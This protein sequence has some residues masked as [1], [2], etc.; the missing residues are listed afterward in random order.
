KIGQ[1]KTRHKFKCH[2]FASNFSCIMSENCFH[3]GQ[4]IIKERIPFDDKVFCCAGCKSVFEILNANDLG[5]FYE[6]NKRSGIR[7]DGA[8]N[9]QFDYLDTPEIFDK[10]TDFSEGTTTLVNF[11]IP[12]IHCSSCIW[13]LESLHTLNSNIHYSQVNFTRKTVQISFNSEEL[14]LSE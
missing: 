6:L 7:P 1:L 12:V 10:V 5:T 11:K 3:C 14:K 8:Q 9:S 2:N 4:N 13:L